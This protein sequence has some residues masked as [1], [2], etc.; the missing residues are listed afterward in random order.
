MKTKILYVERKPSEGAVSIEKVFRQIAKSLSRRNFTTYFQ[1]LEYPNDVLGTLK[2]L[3]FF[4]VEKADVYHITGHVHYIAL[5]LPSEK[6]VLTIH[7]VGILHIRSGLRRYILKKLL[8]DLPIKK[9]KYITAVSEVTK[10]EIVYYTKCK[11]EKIRVIEN[12]LQEHF[13]AGRKKKFNGEFPT[14]LQIGTTA[15]KN[16]DN[17]IKALEGISCQLI[18]VGELADNIINLLKEK[19]I[20]YVNKSNLDN[21]EIREEYI[22]ADIVTFCSTFEG[23]G[24]PIIEAQAMLT[25][26]LT[27]DIS[28]MKEVAGEEG[29]A[30]A[31]PLDSE[32]IRRSILRIINDENYRKELIE[33]GIEN[34]KKYKPEKIAF[35]YENLYREISHEKPLE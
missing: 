3:F 15:N 34:V 5:V 12:P 6:T 21:D 33:S 25:P 22:G 35:L 2:N 29:A 31:N 10:N 19:R 4:H 23:F 7:D 14:I 11:A 32:S 9:L 28:P 26:V 18:I 1:Q 17:L 8:F 13:R 24:L 30:F 27:S 16:L 20:V